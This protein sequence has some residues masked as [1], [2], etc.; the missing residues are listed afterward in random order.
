MVQSHLAPRL[1]VCPEHAQLLIEEYLEP[2]V[3]SGA[4]DRIVQAFAHEL[5]PYACAAAEQV[6]GKKLVQE[7]LPELPLRRLLIFLRQQLGLIDSISLNPDAH[8]V[9]GQAVTNRI[10]QAKLDLA[11]WIAFLETT[12]TATKE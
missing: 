11:D 4:L 3:E 10:T 7:Q 2:L 12:P 8:A 5:A 9:L 1:K 6:I